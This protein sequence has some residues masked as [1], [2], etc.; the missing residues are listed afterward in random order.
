VV[1]TWVVR[2]LAVRFAFV[3]LPDDR[4]V[5]EQPTP[6]IGGAGMFV[7]LLVAIAVASQLP[8]LRPIF[9]GNS[10]P[11]G[12]V[13]GAAVIFVVGM[14]DDVHDMSPPAKLS[15]QVLAGMVLYLS[16]LTMIF[17]HIPLLGTTLS[18]S[19]Q[20]SPLVTVLWVAGMANA[21]N[22]IDGLDGLA[23]GIVGI[24]AA[25]F[26]IYSHELLRTGNILPGNSGPL[27]A[28]IACGICVGFL[29]H[30]FPHQ[31]RIFMGDA[32]AMLLGLLMAAS[33]ISVVGQS[34]NSY[35]SKTYF[36][37]A[38]IVIPFVILGIPI[39]DTAFA[40]VRRAGHGANPAV[41]DKSHLHHRLMRLGHGHT[42][43]VVILWIWTAL[44]SALVLYPSISNH[45]TVLVPIG[46]VALGVALYT[47]FAPRGRQ[48][49]ALSGGTHQVRSGPGADT[50]LPTGPAPG[51]P[52]PAKPGRPE[53]A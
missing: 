29:P 17:F 26:F 22:F 16:G 13:L 32:G 2:R 44:L 1:A 5:H 51:A 6:T 47:L 35:S 20:V 45:N 14:I 23:A 19:P 11:L 4:R 49:A 36:L 7:G 43:S 27:V 30:N 33:T 53:R 38:P 24:A 52:R 9:R 50:A 15:G 31:A 8:G 18:L 28:I 39:L 42:R 21:V 46:V 25:T 10:E 12:L 3:V 40:L 48:V 34:P 37:F 41:A